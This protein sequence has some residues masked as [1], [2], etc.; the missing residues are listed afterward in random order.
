PPRHIEAEGRPIYSAAGDKLGAVV[1]MHDVTER[2]RAR[3]ALEDHAEL[4]AQRVRDLSEL[5]YATSHDLSEPLRGIRGHL[6]RVDLTQLAPQAA[7]A[8]GVAKAEAQRMQALM[9]EYQQ[10]TQLS[11]GRITKLEAEQLERSYRELIEATEIVADQRSIDF[12][13]RFIPTAEAFGTQNAEQAMLQIQLRT[14]LKYPEAVDITGQ[15]I[16][17]LD[18]E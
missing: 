8:V 5:A 17:E 6:D 9:Q 4:L 3:Q 13:F 11:R 16:E 15:V 2:E 12:V 7:E 1:M 14:F 18:L 10:F